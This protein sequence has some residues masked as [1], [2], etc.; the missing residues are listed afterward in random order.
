M[1]IILHGPSLFVVV[2][3]VAAMK[4]NYQRSKFGDRSKTQHL[5]LG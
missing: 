1:H 2:Q 5:L 3:C 4:I